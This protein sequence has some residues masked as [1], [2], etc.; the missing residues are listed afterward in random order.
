M[1]VAVPVRTAN[2]SVFMIKSVL[3]IRFTFESNAIY[4]D[5]NWPVCRVCD[6]RESFERTLTNVKSE[7]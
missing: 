3:L 6:S 4:D 1:K 2:Q 7:T 5:L